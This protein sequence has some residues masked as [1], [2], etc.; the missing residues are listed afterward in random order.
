VERLLED[1]TKLVGCGHRDI[2]VRVHDAASFLESQAAE[3]SLLR[4]EVA[5][6]KYLTGEG[7]KIRASHIEALEAEVA[8]LEFLLDEGGAAYLAISDLEAENAR[9]R[10][11]VSE[12]ADAVGAFCSSD[13]SLEFMGK[14]PKEVRARSALNPE[15]EEK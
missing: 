2:G 12:C 14:V 1:A 9:L 10:E 11:I 8:E 3:N 5:E 15:R 13:A 7:D 4:A 6:L